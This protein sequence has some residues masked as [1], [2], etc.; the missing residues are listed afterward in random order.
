MSYQDKINAFESELVEEIESIP[1]GEIRKDT[2]IHRLVTILSRVKLLNGVGT[3]NGESGS[4]TTPLEITEGIDNSLVSSLIETVGSTDDSPATTNVGS[5]SLIS[6][7]KRL[8]SHLLKKRLTFSSIVA[9]SGDNII[10]QA[11]DANTEYVITLLRVQARS[12]NSTDILIKKGLVDGTPL[13]LRTVSDGGGI[14][15]VYGFSDSIHCGANNPFV[16][17]FSSPNSHG[18]SVMYYTAN[19]STGLPV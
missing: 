5:F 2:N 16:L 6:L 18:V 8:L 7:L 19:V 1:L 9:T 4:S 15:E 14:S 3:S 10:L 17:N 13:R 12:A 11:I